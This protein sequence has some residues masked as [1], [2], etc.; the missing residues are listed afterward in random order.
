MGPTVE[1]EFAQGFVGTLAVGVTVVGVCVPGSQGVTQICQFLAD[2]L[3]YLPQ[4]TRENLP[5]SHRDFDIPG[6]KVFVWV[7][8]V[9]GE[10][11]LDELGLA[12]S[13]LQPPT[14]RGLSAS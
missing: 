6:G 1:A 13:G 3:D 7:V 10:E 14:D 8:L 11:P 2:R 12:L 4:F 5:Q 9:F